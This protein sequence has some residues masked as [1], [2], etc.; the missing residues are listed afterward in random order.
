MVPAER[1]TE[2]W[3][4]KNGSESCSA[5]KNFN[6]EKVIP[7]ICSVHVGEMQKPGTWAAFVTNAAEAHAAFDILVRRRCANHVSICL[8]RRRIFAS[9]A[10]VVWPTNSLS[11]GVLKCFANELFGNIGEMLPLCWSCL[12]RGRWLVGTG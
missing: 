2:T 1:V 5:G 6:A 9:S 3:L 7:D 4:S 12:G 11:V 10:H 8:C